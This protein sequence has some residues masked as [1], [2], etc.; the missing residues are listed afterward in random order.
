MIFGIP[1]LPSADRAVLG[2]IEVLRQELRF[3][4]APP[5]RWFGSLRRAT[6]ARAVQGSN[7][8]EGYR[9][10]VEDVL[11]VLEDEPP[12][13]ADTAT[14]AAL[15][16]YR[17]A[18]PFILQTAPELPRLSESL[19]RSLHFMMMKHDL[20]KHPGRWRPG[21]VHVAGAGSQVLHTAPD[22]ALVEGLVVE[23]PGAGPRA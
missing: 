6:L 13:A 18:M 12:E 14:R 7:S 21:A 2:V 4:L 22:R 20:S 8:I 15:E 5:R 9:A 3:H 23:T 10:S 1:E 17:D 16:G 19:L 11:T